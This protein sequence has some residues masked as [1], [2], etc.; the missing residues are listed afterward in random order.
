MKQNKLT[1]LRNQFDMNN[2]NGQTNLFAKRIGQT[3]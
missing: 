3:N 2:K 1:K